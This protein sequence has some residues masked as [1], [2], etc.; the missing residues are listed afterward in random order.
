MERRRGSAPKTSKP[1][2]YGSPRSMDQSRYMDVDQSRYMDVDQSRYMDVDQ[3]RYMDVDQSRSTKGDRGYHSPRDYSDFPVKVRTVYVYKDSPKKMKRSEPVIERSEPETESTEDVET[4]S[5]EYVTENNEK[6]TKS[7][8]KYNESEEIAEIEIPKGEL[9]ISKTKGVKF[10]V[11]KTNSDE[12]D[13]NPKN[14][15]SKSC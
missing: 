11:T 8:V 10:E 12:D 6:K 5:S 3:S 7:I 4:E 2:V 14:K 9:K 15:L 1:E 13:R